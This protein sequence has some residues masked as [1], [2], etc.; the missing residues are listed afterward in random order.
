MG[1]DN[2][3]CAEDAFAAIGNVDKVVMNET[4]ADYFRKTSNYFEGDEM[5]Q[6][7]CTTKMH[8]D[9]II[10]S[11]KYWEPASDTVEAGNELA[12][13]FDQRK[14]EAQPARPK[15]RKTSRKSI[16]LKGVGFDVQ[17]MRKFSSPDDDLVQ[18]INLEKPCKV[19]MA[20]VL[21]L[22]A[23]S[24]HEW[25]AQMSQSSRELVFKNVKTI[26]EGNR[27]YWSTLKSLIDGAGWKQDGIRSNSAMIMLQ[28]NG[29]W[30]QN[31]WTRN[32]SF[33]LKNSLISDGRTNPV[34]K[35]A[36]QSWSDRMK[37]YLKG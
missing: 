20:I 22:Y 11:S 19:M 13:S 5:D 37:A 24:Q 30:L 9:H 10:G 4:H 26:G 16:H 14:P 12:H 3:N 6:S 2:E 28:D 31:L 29:R 7:F 18:Q 1:K 8:V 34:H 35:D 23:L 33:I 27:S 32:I 36:A 21:I 25:P 17:Y 15:L